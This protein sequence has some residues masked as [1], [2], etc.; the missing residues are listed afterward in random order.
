MLDVHVAL[1]VDAGACVGADIG[2][3]DFVAAAVGAGW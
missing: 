1:D 3:G 2:V